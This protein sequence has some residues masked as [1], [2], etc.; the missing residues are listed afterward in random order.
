MFP[1][2]ATRTGAASCPCVATKV[3][4]A[5]SERSGSTVAARKFRMKRPA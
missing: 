1:A 5:A 4:S 3:A 2:V